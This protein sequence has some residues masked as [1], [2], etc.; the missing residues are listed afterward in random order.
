MCVGAGLAV[1]LLNS[2]F[3]LGIEGDKEVAARDYLTEH[4]HWPDEAPKR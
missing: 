3:R 1:L 2:L 4:G